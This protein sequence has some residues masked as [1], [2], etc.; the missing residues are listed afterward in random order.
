MQTKFRPIAFALVFTFI[1]VNLVSAAVANRQAQPDQQAGIVPLVARTDEPTTI[2]PTAVPPTDVPPTNVPPTD[3]PPPTQTFTPSMTF[4]PSQTFTASMTPTASNTPTTVPGQVLS[5]N[6][7]FELDANDDKVPDGWETDDRGNEK[8]ACN[9]LNRPG[10]PDKI[11]A[12]AG[13]CAFQVKDGMLPLRQIY[14]TP[15]GVAGDTLYLTAWVEGKALTDGLGIK[16]KLLL[17]GGTKQKL[18]LSVAPG[19]YVYSLLQTQFT[20]TVGVTEIKLRINGSNFTGKA[21]I[22]DVVLNLVSVTR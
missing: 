13:A 3:P 15:I 8:F 18:K 1:L 9:K 17:V 10:K 6:G 20:L 16:A 11:V 2:P 5:Q 21:Y 22:D 14:S 19:T 12:Y 4:T 7:G